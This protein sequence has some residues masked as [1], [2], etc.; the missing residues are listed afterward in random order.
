MI[1]SNTLLVSI[2]LYGLVSCRDEVNNRS[3]EQVPQA[4]SNTEHIDDPASETQSVPTDT[5]ETKIVHPAKEISRPI[6][7]TMLGTDCGEL[8]VI[9][10]HEE[11]RKQ[12]TIRQSIFLEEDSMLTFEQ[13]IDD[14]G[15]EDIGCS[16]N[17]S[18]VIFRI[19][20]GKDEY[21]LNSKDLNQFGC[22]ASVLGGNLMSEG[23]LVSAA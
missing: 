2:V 23:N 6:S 21:S 17:R 11:K 19:A 3:N 8:E 4:Q 13:L 1:K 20:S 16:N 22:T 5:S 10:Y 14:P 15:R 9:K 7:I 12:N 18:H